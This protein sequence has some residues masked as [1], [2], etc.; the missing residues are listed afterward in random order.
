LRAK[1]GLVREEEDDPALAADL[2]ARM[3]S[4]GVD[5]TILFRELCA[6]AKDASEDRRIASLFAEPG[7]FHDWSQAWR[8]RLGREDL[9]PDSRAAA[10]RLANPAFVPRNHRVA[11]AIEA[12]VRRDDFDPFETLMRVLG[13]PYEAQP[14]FAHLA[15]PPRPEERVLETFCGT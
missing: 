13:R 2:L 11:Q 9:A 15:D 6:A 4:S 1:L 10:M 14:E 12:A 7:A 3:A 5:F 8:R